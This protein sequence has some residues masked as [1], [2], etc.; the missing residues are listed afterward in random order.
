MATSF[1]K[2]PGYVP[3]HDCTKVDWK[4][5][6]HVKLEEVK[7]PKSAAVPLYA[8]PRKPAP[9]LPPPK[10]PKS[11]SYSQTVFKNPTGDDIT[12]KF[13]PTFV[14]LDK[15]VLR[16]FGYFKE[17]VTESALESYKV[18]RVVVLYYLD[19][20][21]LAVSEPKQVNSGAPQGI[22]L[23]RQMVLR[24]DG[25]GTKVGPTDFLYAYNGYLLE[26]ERTPA[27]TAKP[28]TST[29]ATSTQ[30]SSARM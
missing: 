29:T 4:K 14:K 25:T 24:S 18:R 5:V 26:S 8:L 12:E 11:L 19:D 10:D 23:K 27:S 1:P 30:E 3:I 7:N 16:Y 13:E 9:D 28:S 2:L 6:S 15:Q 17:S 21:T 20:S 22:L